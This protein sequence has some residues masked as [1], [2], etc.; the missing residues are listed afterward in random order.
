R[1]TRGCGCDGCCVV[2]TCA[3]RE[4]PLLTARNSVESG[5]SR[6][7]LGISFFRVLSSSWAAPERLPALLIDVDGVQ[8][9]SIGPRLGSIDPNRDR[10]HVRLLAYAESQAS[11]LD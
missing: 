1:E 11:H 2:D 4:S 9:G 5:A 3:S 10:R 8:P 7:L 6:V